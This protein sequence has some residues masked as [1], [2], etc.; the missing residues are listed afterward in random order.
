MK[1]VVEEVRQV[2]ETWNEARRR[3]A[4]AVAEANRTL[5]NAEMRLDTALHGLP[6]ERWKRLVD[7]GGSLSDPKVAR[8]VHGAS[9]SKD[10]VE[11]ALAA[12]V[13]AQSARDA[14]FRSTELELAGAARRLLS[15]GRLAERVTGCS[16]AELREVAAADVALP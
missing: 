13:E 5:R 2:A 6:L 9:R 16:T 7:D 10:E 3:H 1:M 14:A 11:A 15:Y 12:L 4:A 8:Q